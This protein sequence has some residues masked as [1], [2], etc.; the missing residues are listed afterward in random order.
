M[1]IEVYKL[2]Q[3]RAEITNL[4]TVKKASSKNSNDVQVAF[5]DDILF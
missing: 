5:V 4:K 3:L 2:N 1:G